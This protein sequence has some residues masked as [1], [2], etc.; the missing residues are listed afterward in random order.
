MS[1]QWNRRSTNLNSSKHRRWHRLVWAIAYSYWMQW[2]WISSSSISVCWQTWW[3][4][5]PT[6]VRV[7]PMSRTACSWVS[8]TGSRI[9]YVCSTTRMAAVAILRRRGPAVTL[10]M[11]KRVLPIPQII[12]PL[13]KWYSRRWPTKTQMQTTAQVISQW[14]VVGPT[15]IRK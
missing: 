13:Q 8:A 7:A 2:M 11:L 4:Y 10:G 14:M 15:R 9:R 5:W 3:G 12:R 1:Y 6:G